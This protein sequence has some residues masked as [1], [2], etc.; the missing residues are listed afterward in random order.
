MKIDKSIIGSFVLLV[1]I[2]SLYRIMPGRPLGFAPQI[3]MALF[4]GSI[5]KDKKF[6]FLLPIL[7]MLVSD[8]IYEVLF[9]FNITSVMGFYEGQL[10]NYVLFG[11]LTVI[12]FWIKKENLLHIAGGSIAGAS[13]YFILSNFIVWIGG[14]LGIDNLPYARSWDGLMKCYSEGIPFYL[15]SLVATVFFSGVL[16]GG[17]FLLNKYAIRKQVIA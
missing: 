15:G 17:Y 11:A 16:F 14:G 12:G 1:I 3:A 5:I 13:F 7:S 4:S 2:A 6:S 9:R 10:L 8:I